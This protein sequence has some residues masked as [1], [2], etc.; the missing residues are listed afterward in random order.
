MTVYGC[1]DDEE[2]KDVLV[3]KSHDQGEWCC[4]V[5]DSGL[6]LLAQSSTE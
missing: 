5:C 2:G 6:D 3:Q 4:D 1:F